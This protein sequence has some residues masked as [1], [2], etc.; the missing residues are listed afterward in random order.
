MATVETANLNSDFKYFIHPELCI[1]LQMKAGCFHAAS[2]LLF[3]TMIY[4]FKVLLNVLQFQ[5][6]SDM[7]SLSHSACSGY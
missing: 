7:Y 6:C 5:L 3:Y 2:P 1:R 4:T